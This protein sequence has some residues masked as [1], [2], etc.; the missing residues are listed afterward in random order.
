MQGLDY[1]ARVEN[2]MSDIPLSYYHL[3]KKAPF[4]QAPLHWHRS[5]EII[6]VTE[7]KLH[8][9]LEDQSIACT[10]GE[11]IF[12]NRNVIH[13]FFPLE[14][15]YEIIDFDAEKLFLQFGL[16]R[17]VFR[18]FT[19]RHVRVAPTII[20][21][22][23]PIYSAVDRLF[24]IAAE[25]IENEKLIIL[26]ALFE[27]IGM[28][29]ANAL[30]VETRKEITE[31]K[32]TEVFKPVLKHIEKHYMNPITL[33]SL[34]QMAGMSVSYFSLVF[35]DT[36]Q[37]TPIDY[38]NYY[39]IEQACLLLAETLLPITEVAYRCGFNDS[40]YFVKVFKKYKKLTPKK[41]R[42]SLD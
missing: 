27:L 4:Y 39:R 32:N 8:F 7:G 29:H 11:I 10:A 36:F 9:F 12:V 19:S 41:Y 14:C 22:S 2:E 1:N 15:V 38:L 13:G 17:D 21:K 40:A 26:G 31:P 35:R 16:C 33:V 3:D 28:I 37:Q 23:S 5:F 20:D 24:R 30:Y 25:H 34:A 18:I 42:D 6:R